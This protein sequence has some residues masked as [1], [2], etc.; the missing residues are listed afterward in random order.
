MPMYY[1]NQ[2]A[3]FLANNPTFHECTKHT[4]IDC[5]AICHWVLDRLITTPHIGSFHQLAAILRKG[6]SKASYDSIS[7]KL[8]LFDLH[9]S[10]WGE[11]W[12]YMSHNGTFIILDFSISLL[13]PICLSSPLFFSLIKIIVSFF[14]FHEY[15][16]SLRTHVVAWHSTYWSNQIDPWL[17]KI[18]DR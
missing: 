17:I 8:G 15:F 16:I 5:Y 6:L 11:V 9:A 4:E 14:I 7:C 13:S 1:G 3:I 18:F 10:T 2:A 12:V